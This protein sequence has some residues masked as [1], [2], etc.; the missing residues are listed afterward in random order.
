MAVSNLKN[1]ISIIEQGTSGIWTY[2]K[3]SDGTAECWGKKATYS[4]YG[5]WVSPIYYT[6]TYAGNQNYP[7]G[8]FVDVP[9]CTVS[10]VSNAAGDYWVGHTGIAA[11]K[12]Y[13]PNCYVLSAGTHNAET[14]TLSYYAIGKW[15]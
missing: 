11:T 7:N 9:I 6:T 1:N 10:G 12:D 3:W 5:V 15:K 8:L 4:A 2:R 14:Y 13:T